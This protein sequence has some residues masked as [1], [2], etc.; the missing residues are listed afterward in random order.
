[1]QSRGQGRHSFDACGQEEEEE[2][3]EE[4]EG[5]LGVSRGCGS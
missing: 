1:M 2:E 4:E 3:E 5:H